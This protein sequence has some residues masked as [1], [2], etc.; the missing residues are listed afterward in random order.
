[1]AVSSG[2]ACASGGKEPSHVLTAMGMD[3]S[4]AQSAIRVSLGV[5][6]TVAEITQF[7]TL[8]KNLVCQEG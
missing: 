4:L 5:A 7:I 1:V 3:S 8:L 6:N 2:S